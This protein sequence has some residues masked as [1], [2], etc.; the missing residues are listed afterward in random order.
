LLGSATEKLLM[1][2][3]VS[4]E[5]CYMLETA[6]W[7][8]QA[9]VAFL[10][11][12]AA[13]E[14]VPVDLSPADSERMAELVEQYADFPLGELRQASSQLLNDPERPKSRHSTWSAI[15]AVTVRSMLCGSSSVDMID[16]LLLSSFAGRDKTCSGA[17]V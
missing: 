11:L 3:T 15:G 14:L 6:S 12:F 4:A 9:G 13:G 1:P 2:A 5:I 8:R 16:P 7:Q 17:G 10:R